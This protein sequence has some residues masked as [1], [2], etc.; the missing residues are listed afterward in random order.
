MESE[1]NSKKMKIEHRYLQIVTLNNEKE[2][3]YRFLR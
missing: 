1:N 3:K 2:N